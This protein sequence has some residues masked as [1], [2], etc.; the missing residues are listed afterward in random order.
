MKSCCQ[1][2]Q[3]AYSHGENTRICVGQLGSKQMTYLSK[4]ARLLFS[5]ANHT[6]IP[7]TAVMIQPVIPGP[8]AKLYSRNPTKPLRIRTDLR[9]RP[10]FSMLSPIQPTISSGTSQ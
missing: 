3:T 6:M 9:T 10:T 2:G 8:V 4:F 7:S 1:R 5:M